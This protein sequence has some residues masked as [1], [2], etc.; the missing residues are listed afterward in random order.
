MCKFDAKTNWWSHRMFTLSQA[1]EHDLHLFFYCSFAK[2]AWKILGFSRYKLLSRSTSWL[3][4]FRLIKEL[5]LDGAQL[6]CCFYV[7]LWGIWKSR[8]SWIFAH[9]RDEPRY[10][11]DSSLKFLEIFQQ[12]G[13]A[14][15]MGAEYRVE[16]PS[17]W[18]PPYEGWLKLNF[19]ASFSKSGAGFGFVLRNHLGK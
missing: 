11:I 2:L 10:V 3:Q 8:N 5:E 4:L 7:C 14:D 16:H 18:I 15:A 12:A 1:K 19:D 17:R 6:L 9:K 13:A